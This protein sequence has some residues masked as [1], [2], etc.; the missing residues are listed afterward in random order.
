MGIRLLRQ[1]FLDGPVLSM[2]PA[3]ANDELQ[4]LGNN[5]IVILRRIALILWVLLLCSPA[6]LGMP[7]F[8]IC[9]Q[10]KRISSS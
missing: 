1:T 2:H 6:C 7:S 9:I 8:F 5:I 3:T 10:K 4:S